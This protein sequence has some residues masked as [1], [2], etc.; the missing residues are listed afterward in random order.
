MIG[1][2]LDDL[3]LFEVDV[4][5]V[6]LKSCLIEV[7]FVVMCLCVVDK[8]LCGCGVC[9]VLF[10]IC[11]IFDFIDVGNI[12]FVMDVFCVDC[13]EVNVLVMLV[14]LEIGCIVY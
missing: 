7:S 4:V 10:K 11:L 13:G 8:W 6:L 5:V 14:F 9:Y 2:F 12:G 1:V 3:V